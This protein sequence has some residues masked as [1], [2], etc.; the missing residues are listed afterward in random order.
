[1]GRRPINDLHGPPQPRRQTHGLARPH[2][3]QRHHPI[4]PQR[5]VGR[6]RLPHHRPPARHRRRPAHADPNRSRNRRSSRH[7][8]LHGSLGRRPQSHRNVSSGQRR[9]PRGRRKHEHLQVPTLRQAHRHL[10]PRRRHKNR[11]RLWRP[12]PRR[13]RNRPPHPYRRRHRQ[14]S[15]RPGR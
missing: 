10:R 9:S 1:P 6:T 15:S 3:P 4:S 5:R 14:T 13:N 2:A 8:A 11:Y 12:R 7:H